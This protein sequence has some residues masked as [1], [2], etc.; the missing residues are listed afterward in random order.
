MPNPCS[1]V[2]ESVQSVSIEYGDFSN[3]PFTTL[4]YSLGCS[5]IQESILYRGV[6]P[7]KR[8]NTHGNVQEISLLDAGLDK[9]VAC[10]FSSNA[11]LERA[12]DFCIK[13]GL[14][15]VDISADDSLTYSLSD[16]SRHE[17]SL[18]LKCEELR[19]LGLIFAVHIFPRDQTLEPS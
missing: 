19:V 1:P 14:I 13:A 7:Q 17:I 15:R 16:Q 12:I 4:L 5:E 11:R 6:S 10:L 3:A 18:S 2:Q 9:R 8:W